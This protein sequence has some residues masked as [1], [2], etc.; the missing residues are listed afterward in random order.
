MYFCEWLG[1]LQCLSWGH[2]LSLCC[3]RPALLWRWRL[4]VP[5]RL[6]QPWPNPANP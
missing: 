4:R 1:W 6:P 5:V 2:P 3:A